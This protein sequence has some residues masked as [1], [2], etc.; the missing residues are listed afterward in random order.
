MK[1]L[2]VCLDPRQPFNSPTGGGTRMRELVAA[3]REEGHQVVVYAVEEGGAT[4]K[5]G[6]KAPPSGVNPRLRSLVKPLTPAQLWVLLRDLNDLRIDRIKE[7][8]L[9]KLVKSFAPDIIYERNSYLYGG[10]ARVAARTGVP[11]FVSFNA[12]TAEERSEMFGAPL[13]AW[14]HRVEAFQY[15]VARGI[16]VVSEPLKQYMLKSGVEGKKIAIVPNGVRPQRFEGSREKAIEIRKKLGLKGPV[17]GF[18]GSIASY[19]RLD[20]L[21]E[22]IGEVRKKFTH[23]VALI[24]G[25]GPF[26]DDV[27]KRAKERGLG[28]AVR[29]TGTVKTEDVPAYI[30]AFD[31]AIL[32]GTAEYCNPI[33]L[34][35]YGCAGIPIIAPRTGP[36]V[37]IMGSKDN[38][39]IVEEEGGVAGAIEEILSDKQKAGKMA[40]SF[41]RR[42]LENYTWQ[43]AAK[44]VIGFIEQRLSDSA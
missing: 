11:Y 21:F 6:A 28:D 25:G 36:V 19:H 35:E 5:N 26:L 33:K 24:V 40:E 42:V 20:L 38:G 27:K 2:Y 23:A 34:F 8:E 17:I 31:V 39:V 4:A 13:Q 7:K 37:E 32:P 3:L 16:F 10:C 43:H 29:F 30:C 12:P 1:I 15:K 14:H 41:K 44:Q 18:V 22:A 9:E